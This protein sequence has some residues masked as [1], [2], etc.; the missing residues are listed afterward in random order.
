[1]VD[2]V[3]KSIRTARLKERKFQDAKTKEMQGVHEVLNDDTMSADEKY[4]TLITTY[5]FGKI[6]AQQ[7]VYGKQVFEVKTHTSEKYIRDMGK[8]YG[9][10]D[11]K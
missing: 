11:S 5:H 6:R 2:E 1:M 7:L 10:G 4:F 3:A 8:Y 9:K